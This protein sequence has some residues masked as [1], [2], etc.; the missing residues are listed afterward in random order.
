MHFREIVT[1]HTHPYQAG[2]LLRTSI[3]STGICGGSLITNRAVLT[4]AHCPEGAQST[5]VILGAHNIQT[6]EPNQQRMTVHASSYIIHPQYNIHTISNDIAILIL[7]SAATLNQY[8]A[9]TVLPDLGVTDSFVGQTATV[10]GWGRVSDSSTITSPHLRSVENT[11]ITNAVCQATFGS[12]V[13]E[14]IICISTVRGRGICNGDSGGPLTVSSGNDRLQVGIV[15]FSRG[16]ERG[17]PAGF[18]RVTSF[19][20]WIIDNQDT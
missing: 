4:A 5:Q 15:S 11:I 12:M 18:V 16:C 2:L 9:L 8:V 14:S 20:Q 17:F 6:I 19:R 7:P 3:T 1:P 13:T 10:S